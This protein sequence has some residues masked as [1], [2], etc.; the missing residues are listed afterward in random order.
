MKSFRSLRAKLYVFNPDVCKKNEYKYSGCINGHNSL[1]SKNFLSKNTNF[2]VADI[3]IQNS[4]LIISIFILLIHDQLFTMTTSYFGYEPTTGGY[5]SAAPR[6]FAAV[7]LMRLMSDDVTLAVL[8]GCRLPSGVGFCLGRA[9]VQFRCVRIQIACHY[10]NDTSHF[11]MP[12]VSYS[13]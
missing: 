10:K 8:Q 13:V 5:R 11:V 2:C 1:K 3:N 12:S 4:A 7:G 6:S 9:T